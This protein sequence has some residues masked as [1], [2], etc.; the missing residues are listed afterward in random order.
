MTTTSSTLRSRS[1]LDRAI[2]ASVAAMLAMNVFIFTQQLQAP[3][4]IAATH[5]AAAQV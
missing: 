1:M 3:V 2:L 4:A 5:T